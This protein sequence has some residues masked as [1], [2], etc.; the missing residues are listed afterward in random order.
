MNFFLNHLFIALEV[1]E[2]IFKMGA[3]Q[4]PGPDGLQALFYHKYYDVVGSD[5]IDAVLN[6]L[7]NDYFIALI[8]K[9]K[10]LKNM[11]QFR[12][13]SPCNVFYKIIS[14]LLAER[15]KAV[16]PSLISYSQSAFMRNRYIIDNVLIGHELVH[17]LKHKRIGKE[18]YMA[19]KLDISKA[20]DRVE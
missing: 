14:K 18:G 7:N 10:S 13:I 17:V 4:S 15:L 6:F 5:V 8:P 12:P 3:L 1:K 16:L 9:I 20:Y 2:A 19:W 11:K